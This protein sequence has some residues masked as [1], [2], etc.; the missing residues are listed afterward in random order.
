MLCR[1]SDV[2]TGE[3]GVCVPRTCRYNSNNDT[4]LGLL[5]RGLGI[6]T[7]HEISPSK[8]LGNNFIKQLVRKRLFS[9]G[10]IVRKA[11]DQPQFEF[12][13]NDMNKATGLSPKCL[14]LPWW[15]MLRMWVTIFC[16]GKSWQHTAAWLVC[17][18]LT[19]WVVVGAGRLVSYINVVKLTQDHAMKISVK[20]KMRRDSKM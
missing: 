12:M 17:G 18:A 5:K 10:Y 9:S 11:G 7:K 4:N 15:L 8:I 13:F 3:S 14:T 1:L 16:F 20:C 6:E 2:R 19:H